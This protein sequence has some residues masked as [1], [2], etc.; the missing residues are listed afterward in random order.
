MGIIS[1]LF[2]F[3]QIYQLVPVIETFS[4]NVSWLLGSIV[5]GIPDMLLLITPI[6]LPIAVFNSTSEASNNSELVGLQSLGVPLKSLLVRLLVF[7][8]IVA[9]ILVFFRVYVNPISTYYSLKQLS[10][11]VNQPKKINFNPQSLAVFNNNLVY[12]ERQEGDRLVN[13]M[14]V[15]N[16]DY[17][18][19]LLADYALTEFDNAS[20]KINLTLINGSVYSS[21]KGKYYFVQSFESY[22]FP[23]DLAGGAEFK[24]RLENE[25]LWDKD[26]SLLFREKPDKAKSLENLFALMQSPQLSKNDKLLSRL[27]LYDRILIF[28]IT[29]AF[30]I[31]AFALGIS[32]PRFP[33][34][35]NIV[36]LLM[37]IIASS[38]LNTV[39]R[40]L[41]SKQ[42]FDPAIV[43]ISPVIVAIAG[44]I[45][46][47]FANKNSA[48]S[49]FSF[50]I[51]AF[52]KKLYS[53]KTDSATNIDSN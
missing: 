34:K 39:F 2:L 12:F 37:G 47:H 19:I 40:R 22:Q 15:V 43:F 53:K 10:F 6:A 42:D 4:F 7:I 16:T 44:I 31:F 13:L 49:F 45:I 33:I 18:V 36:M 9:A 3:R 41:V 52:V 26:P 23:I 48:A 8:S 1:S 21:E 35:G 17:P 28:P 51:P 25:S 38:Q 50:K 5:F 24:D 27:E 11:I 46:F 20:K 14:I 30:A 29:I 32:N